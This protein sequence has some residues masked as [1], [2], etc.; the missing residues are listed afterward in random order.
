MPFAATWMDRETITLSEIVTQ[1]KR[2]TNL[3]NY[4]NG[5]IYKIETDLQTSKANLWLPKETGG[6]EGI[7]WE[8]GIGICALRHVK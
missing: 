7:D 8:L 1:T 6:E 2:K 5:I 4:T 3:G